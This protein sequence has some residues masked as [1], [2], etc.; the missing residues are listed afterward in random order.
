M[1]WVW[2][3]NA[4]QRYKTGW[5]SFY[6]CRSA[7]CRKTRW[8]ARRWHDNANTVGK[9]SHDSP[10]NDGRR[11]KLGLANVWADA[12]SAT[13]G[14]CQWES[15]WSRKFEIMQWP[16]YWSNHIFL[17]A[18]HHRFHSKHRKGT[19]W[20]EAQRC[21]WNSRFGMEQRPRHQDAVQLVEHQS[22]SP[23]ECVQQDNVLKNSPILWWILLTIATP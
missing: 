12:V 3:T 10:S 20:W 23:R 16:T 17:G 13:V 19:L 6:Q 18:S 15:R 1:S 21:A 9:R 4:D 2:E 8:S 11:I 7:I 22:T 14:I 5:H